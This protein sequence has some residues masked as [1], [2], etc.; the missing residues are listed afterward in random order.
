MP[1]REASRPSIAHASSCSLLPSSSC[2]I[3]HSVFWRYWVTIIDLGRALGGRDAG[4]TDREEHPTSLLSNAMHSG[5]EYQQLFS[6]MTLPSSFKRVLSTHPFIFT[7][8]LRFFV[9][10][11][12]HSVY[13]HNTAHTPHIAHHRSPPPRT[14]GAL[15]CTPIHICTH[16]APETASYAGTRAH[17]RG[18]EFWKERSR[19]WTVG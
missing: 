9:L 16:T 14:P 17:A 6:F 19:G 10:T 2:C 8:P 3:L 18:G 13:I 7:H 15:H 5:K 11:G 4:R 1:S 12:T